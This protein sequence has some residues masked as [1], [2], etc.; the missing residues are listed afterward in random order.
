MCTEEEFKD[1]NRG[2][3]GARML[4]LLDLITQGND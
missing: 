3:Q 2:K 4:M 1:E